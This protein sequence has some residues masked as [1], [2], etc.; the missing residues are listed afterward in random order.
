MTELIAL[1]SLGLAAY[2]LAPSYSANGDTKNGVSER[3]ALE[4]REAMNYGF[5]R[6]TNTAKTGIIASEETRVIRTPDY[7]KNQVREN[8]AKA[9]LYQKEKNDMIAH[10]N[11]GA[12]ILYNR[13]TIR[14]SNQKRPGLLMVPTKEAGWGEAFDD[15]A[16]VTYD[17]ESGIP[18]DQM[19][20]SWRDQ[21]GDAG[22]FP[23]EGRSQ[24]VLNELYTGNPW[25]AGGQLFVA[26][27]NQHRNPGFGDNSPGASRN[28]FNNQADP[29]PASVKLKKRVRF[30]NDSK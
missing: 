2:Y 14:P 10:M 22:G 11:N 29:T 12:A 6:G 16:N 1:A 20:T 30:S 21:Y 9:W 19:T 17:I 4:M 23:R 28:D 5:L 24:V 18:A 8:A 3:N 26:V 7:N 27:G 25:G 13:G 15:I